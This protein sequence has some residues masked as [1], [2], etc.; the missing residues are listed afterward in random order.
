MQAQQVPAAADKRASIFA[1]SGPVLKRAL[2]PGKTKKKAKE[3]A[4]GSIDVRKKAKMI[5]D[6]GDYD[7]LRVT[8]GYTTFNSAAQPN[9]STIERPKKP[10]TKRKLN[11]VAAGPKAD[12]TFFGAMTS[13]REKIIGPKSSHTRLPRN[14]SKESRDSEEQIAMLI[15]NA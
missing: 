1:E 3:R 8:H 12:M 10:R 14:V 6:A 15:Q 9:D 4:P 11:P 2:R 5:S 13:S 7:E